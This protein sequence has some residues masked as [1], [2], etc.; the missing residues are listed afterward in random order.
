MRIPGGLQA[1]IFVYA[2][3]ATNC[4]SSSARIDGHSPYQVA[5]DLADDGDSSSSNRVTVTPNLP[6]L[7]TRSAQDSQGG[8]KDF[9][10]V[11]AFEGRPTSSN[12]GLRR[13]SAPTTSR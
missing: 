7:G 13:S 5:F 6:P 3:Q 9:T 2:G 8:L 10:W 1:I 11:M 12:F 4:V